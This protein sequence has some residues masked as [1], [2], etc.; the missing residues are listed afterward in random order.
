MTPRKV[1]HVITRLD[2]GGSAQNTMRTVLGHD[3]ALF[4]PMIVTGMAE[5]WDAQGGQPATDANC[6]SLE[7][8]HIRYAMLPPLVREINLL[9]DIRALWAL[10]GLFRREQPQ[11]VHTHTSKAG[12]LGRVAAW[13]AKVPVIVHTPHGHVFYGHFGRLRSWIFMQVERVLSVLTSRL[14]ALTESERDEHLQRHIGCAGHF[15]VVPSGIDL[16]KFRLARSRDV[17]RPGRFPWPPDAVVVGSVGWLTPI[18]GH[19][20][21]IEAAAGMLPTCPHLHVMIVGSGELRDELA[22]MGRR[23]GVGDR[24]HLLGHREDVEA[25]LAAMDIFVLPSLNEGMGR[26]LV[27]AMAAGLPVVATKV[28]GV[29]AVVQDRHNGLLVPPGNA[30]ALADALRSL[31]SRPEWMKQLGDAAQQS[32]GERYGTQAM[33]RSIEALYRESLREV[34]A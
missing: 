28:G 6:R 32:I 29:P 26:A 2:Y 12:V 18:K 15:A 1:I 25:C 7:K 33:V 27:E 24:V 23:L 21:L 13:L 30:S 20:Y 4:A 14:I 34:I 9:N 8:E 11:I 5:R 10:V 31:L 17:R 19:R 16:E 22:A 3:R